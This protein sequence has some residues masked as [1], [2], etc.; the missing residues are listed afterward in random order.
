MTGNGSSFSDWGK[1]PF[2]RRPV[3]WAA[4]ATCF[5]GLGGVVLVGVSGQTVLAGLL[6]GV[7]FAAL[8]GFAWTL[9]RSRGNPV[10][11]LLLDA[12]D[13]NRSARLLTT[14]EGDF[15]YANP[16]F[17]RLFA[18][19][20]SLDAVAALLEGGQEAVDSF[21]RLRASAATRVADRAEL[22]I[23]LPPSDAVEWRRIS[24]IP[25]RGNRRFVLWRAENMTAERELEAARRAEEERLADY[26]DRMPAGF[27]SADAK[28]RVLFANQTLCDWLGLATEDVAS[29]RP[30]F[31]DFVVSPCEPNAGSNGD[32]VL[33]HHDGETFRAGLVQTVFEGGDGGMAYTR[34]LVLRDLV[35]RGKDG[36]REEASLARKLRW[37]FDE[38]PVGIILLDMGGDVTDCN[39][40]FLKMIGLHRD[41]VVGR[42][43]TDRLNKEDRS[44]AAAQVSKVVM[45]TSRAATLDV[46]MPCIGERELI[47]SLYASRLEEADGEVSGLVLHFI[48]TTEQKDLEVQFAQSQKMEAVGQLAGG[49]AHDFNN[50]L[51]AMIGFCDLLLDRHGPGDSSFADIMQIKQNANRATNLVRQ[52]LAFS[53]KQPMKPVVLDVTGGIGDLANL[54]GRLIGENIEL[55]IEHGR[56]LFPVRADANQFDQI[57]VNLAVNARDAMAGGGTL[58]LRTSNVTLDKPV[59]RSAERMPAG[60][61]V[62]VEVLD[63]GHGIAKENLG[64]IFD[65]FFTTKGPGAGTGLGL[66]TAYG[67]V[68]QSE[69]FIFV[70]SALGEG[71]TFSIYLPRWKDGEDGEAATIPVAQS[72]PPEVDLTGVGTVLMVEDEDAVRMFGARALRNK[73]YEVLEATNGEEA[74]DVINQMEASIDLIVSDVVMPGMDGHTLTQL[75]RQEFPGVKIILMSG[76]AEDV[77]SESIQ[78]DPGVTFLGKPFT[79]KD[80]ASTVKR[81]MNG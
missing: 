59:E 16:A 23:R 51:T 75:V 74:L 80:L 14:V 3:A 37:L 21:E 54:L 45:G 50:L 12:A 33:R 24:V 11:D 79:L 35:R 25:L 63:T 41:A 47:A 29:R 60:D 72:A 52:M 19:A 22:S 49:V 39:R 76:Y 18:M 73:G 13:L 46:R 65:P 8:L 61:Y 62:M 34:S 2:W 28:G 15:V 57:V 44:E 48:D 64:R 20:V 66:S 5:G 58:T 7:G 36:E 27:F 55:T 71:T 67:I 38:A 40:A 30:H 17:H 4:V 42:P 31:A 78:A 69:G 1:A 26:L 10:A 9:G 77:L 56:D 70:D 68:R 6:A 43:F 81:V 32:I 53:R